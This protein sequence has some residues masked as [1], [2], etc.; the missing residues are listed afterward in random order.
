[1][2]TWREETAAWKKNSSSDLTWLQTFLRWGYQT[3]SGDLTWPDSAFFFMK[4][5][6]WIVRKSHQVWAE[7]LEAFGNGTR[8]NLKGALK[9]PPARN[10]V[11]LAQGCA[12]KWGTR[13][14]EC[15]P[16]MDILKM[17]RGPALKAMT[18]PPKWNPGCATAWRSFLMESRQHL[19]V[20]FS[21]W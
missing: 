18:P 14:A 1:M 9:P 2:N 3:R 6:H 16:N 21:D 20:C 19:T 4:Y 15:V 8:K 7:N 17:G 5:A 13:S 12:G 10:R 11:K